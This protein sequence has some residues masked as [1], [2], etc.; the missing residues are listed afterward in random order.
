MDAMI[1]I[2]LVDD[3]AMVREGTAELLRRVS[4]FEIVAEASD[5]QQ[6]VELAQELRP[7]VVVMDV[8][9]PVMSGHEATRRI[10]EQ[11]PGVK[12]LVLSAYDDD[13]FVFSLLQAGASGYL[14]KTA[15]IDEL[16]RAIYQVH[17][18]DFPLHPLIVRKIVLNLPSQQGHLAA[19]TA[20]AAGPPADSGELTE[21]LT[22]REQQV[23][24]LLAQGLPNREIAQTLFLSERTVQA[25][26]TRIFAKM[27]VTSRLEAVL[28][29]VRQGWLTLGA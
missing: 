6:A 20:A 2:M 4:D 16:V 29:A 19:A 28:L 15:P 7:D 24:Q 26:L 10:S 13:H 17:A 22:E 9:M 5:G 1:R 21:E 18:G 23:L 8:R 25:H 27:G 11:A 3:H 12:V 14:L